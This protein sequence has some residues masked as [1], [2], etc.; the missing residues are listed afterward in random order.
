MKLSFQHLLTCLPAPRKQSAGLS[1]SALAEVLNNLGLEVTALQVHEVPQDPA[2]KVGSILKRTPHGQADRLS[3]CSVDLGT[4]PPLSI[5]CGA[6]NFKETDKVAVATLGARLPNGTRIRQVTLRGVVSEGM[7][8]SEA[9][10]GL[11]PDS[12]GL[13]ILPQTSPL[14]KPLSEVLQADAYLELELNANRGDCLSYQGIAREVAAYL[15]F[16]TPDNFVFPPPPASGELAASAPPQSPASA[17]AQPVA[18]APPFASGELA[19]SVASLPPLAISLRLATGLCSSYQLY[20]LEGVGEVPSPVLW[21]KLLRVSNLQSVTSLVDATNLAMLET[22]QPL[23]A[24]DADKIQGSLTVREA[25]SGE[26]LEALDGKDYT[27]SAGMVVVA[28]AEKILALVGILGARACAISSGTRR[29]FLEAACVEAA[30]VRATSRALGL[31]TES[32]RRFSKGVDPQGLEKGLGRAVELLQSC[33]PSLVLTGSLRSG[34]P[35]PPRRFLKVC[36]D[37]VREAYGAVGQEAPCD[38]LMLKVWAALGFKELSAPKR[39]VP[40]RDSS[41]YTLEVPSYRVG[42]VV[43][44]VDLIEEFVRLYGIRCLKPAPLPLPA[45]WQASNQDRPSQAC[46]FLLSQGFSECKTL[47]LVSEEAFKKAQGLPLPLDNPL[48][49]E[50]A[51]PRASV[52]PAL[53]RVA[54]DNQRV[55]EQANRLFEHG[56][57]FVAEGGA[58]AEYVEIGFILKVRHAS[59]KW[60]DRPPPDFYTAKAL[61]QALAYLLAAQHARDFKVLKDDA[62]FDP[63]RAGFATGPAS[64]YARAG[65]V[66]APQLSELKSGYLAGSVRMAV[67]TSALQATATQPV[68]FQPYSDQAYALRHLALNVPLDTSAY[69]VEKK[70]W[71]LALRAT[72]GAFACESIELFDAYKA[73]E[74]GPRRK[75][76]AF[77]LKFRPLTGADSSLKDEVV[78]QA[79]QRLREGLAEQTH[80]QVRET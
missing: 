70:V 28:D 2:L 53:L 60:R 19:A 75:S 55:G 15:H 43:E 44:E 31:A 33:C 59:R 3:L 57:V 26:L 6:T 52:L 5:V 51:C 14:G 13:L 34:A 54:L 25:E 50:F 17:L 41:V 79:F 18:P 62:F 7:L 8:C 56:H 48:S 37:R 45:P 42:D 74:L 64:L 27:L 72:A 12:A 4:G 78:Q 21:Q 20:G 30:C 10:L 29:V 35:P 80:W 22:G 76:L 61:T 66:A 58:L 67:G 32:A 47:S 46:Q 39:N 16:H 9:E 71:H 40:P 11:G 73:E 24:F 63:A 65:M 23:H 36:G 68:K 49:Q 69:T 77:S 38:Q 1:V